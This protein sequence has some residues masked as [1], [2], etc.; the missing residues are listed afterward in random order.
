MSVDPL[1]DCRPPRRDDRFAFA[2][3]HPELIG[4]N[5]AIPPAAPARPAVATSR[6]GVSKRTAASLCFVIAV[7]LVVPVVNKSL[8]TE[9]AEPAKERMGGSISCPDVHRMAKESLSQLVRSAR[10]ADL[11]KV[12]DSIAAMR[13]ARRNCEAGRVAEAAVAHR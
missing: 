2:S 9:A 4:G 11:R 3:I 8:R 13:R 12:S 1:P 6:T 10:D 7:L 5:L